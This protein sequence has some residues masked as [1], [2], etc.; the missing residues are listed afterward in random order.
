MLL[1]WQSYAM[2]KMEINGSDNVSN[3]LLSHN[4]CPGGD[5]EALFLYNE[6]PLAIPG[7][8]S[9]GLCKVSYILQKYSRFLTANCPNT[10]CSN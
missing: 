6:K 2:S 9:N 10:F 5:N 8:Q 4:S 1:T 3:W 7:C